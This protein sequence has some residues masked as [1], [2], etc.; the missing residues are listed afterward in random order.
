MLQDAMLYF[1]KI[2][3]VSWPEDVHLDFVKSL[4]RSLDGFEITAAA[5]TRTSSRTING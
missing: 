1:A 2:E 5:E 4:D 3:P